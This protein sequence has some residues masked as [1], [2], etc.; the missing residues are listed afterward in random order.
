MTKDEIRELAEADLETFIRLVAPWQV[1]GGIHSEWCRWTTSEEA[2]SH[3]LTLLPRDHG[4]SR[5]VAF[6][7]AW[8]VVKRPDIRILYISSTS[9]LA[10]KQLYFIKQIFNPCRFSISFI[11]FKSN[12]W[13]VLSF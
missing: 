6:K 2:G 4:K 10:E 8:M 1:I 5:Y 11:K 3:Q 9:N 12:L 13:Y 7:C